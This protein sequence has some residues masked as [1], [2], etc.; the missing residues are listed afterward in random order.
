I[1]TKITH[2]NSNQWQVEAYYRLHFRFARC[3]KSCLCTLLNPVA[4]ASDTG[5]PFSQYVASS[6]DPQLPLT[7]MNCYLGLSSH[8]GLDDTT[9]PTCLSSGVNGCVHVLSDL[10]LHLRNQASV[11]GPGLIP[12]PRRGSRSQQTY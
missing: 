2:V 7:R 9:T 5:F 1:K 6:T 4:P 11:I 8:L 12:W 10:F 3:C